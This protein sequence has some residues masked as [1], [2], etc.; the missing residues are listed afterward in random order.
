MIYSF[1]TVISWF[2]I[3]IVILSALRAN[4]NERI[5]GNSLLGFLASV[6]WLLV[7]YFA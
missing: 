6:A 3:V 5:N 1:F 2:W 7:R 4:P